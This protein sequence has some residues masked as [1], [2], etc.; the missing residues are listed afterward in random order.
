MVEKRKKAIETEKYGFETAKLKKGSD[1]AFCNLKQSEID[2]LRKKLEEVELSQKKKERRVL[3]EGEL[4]EKEEKKEVKRLEKEAREREVKDLRD[5]NS[6][7]KKMLLE[8][9]DIKV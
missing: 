2:G 5:E 6:K 4:K 8:K 1:C 7:L 9:F 3:T